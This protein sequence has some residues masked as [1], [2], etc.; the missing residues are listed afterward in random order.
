MRDHDPRRDRDDRADS[1]RKDRDVRG[2]HD[3]GPDH[4]VARMND[5]GK[6]VGAQGGKQDSHHA[7]NNVKSGE[8]KSQV[9]SNKSDHH[10]NVPAPKNKGKGK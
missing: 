6:H 3:R 2:S 4:N 8:S 9:T 1:A 10:S 5:V 7:V